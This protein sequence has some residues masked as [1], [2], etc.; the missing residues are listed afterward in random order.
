MRLGLGHLNKHKFKYGFN[1]KI[2]PICICGDIESINH[3]ILD[4][5]EL[6][7][8][9]QVLRD[10]IQSIDIP[11]FS[12]SESLLARLR[13]YGDPKGNS[14]VNPFFLNSTSKF[15]LSSRRLYGPLLNEA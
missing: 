8:A 7:E 2:N 6:I 1:D 5:R 10:N 3:F 9:R 12:Q 13:L 14:N 15:I 4:Y 11:L